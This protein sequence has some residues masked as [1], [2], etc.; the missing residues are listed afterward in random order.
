MTG[1]NPQSQAKYI[2]M[3][4]IGLPQSEYAIGPIKG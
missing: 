2:T 3:P 4:M 1:G